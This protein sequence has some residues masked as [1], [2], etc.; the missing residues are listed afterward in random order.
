MRSLFDFS[1]AGPL[2]GLVAS[3]AMLVT[4][5]DMTA[6]ADLQQIADLPALPLYLLRSSTLGGGL[7]E[8]F[9]GKGA[10]MQDL[11]ADT[12]LPLHPFAV[13]GYV[14]IMVNSLAL[15]PLGRTCG[16]KALSSVVLSSTHIH[17]RLS[18]RHGWWANIADHVRPTRSFCC[19]DLHGGTIVH[20]WTR[21]A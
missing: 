14:G 20:C 10:L 2:A 3:V 15:L 6:S 9:L 21:W 19:K 13:A 16:D 1:I 11:S 7:I 12:V 8:L 5:L 17:P 18:R 4:G